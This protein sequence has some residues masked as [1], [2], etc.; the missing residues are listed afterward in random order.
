M[1]NQDTS[2]DT[3]ISKSPLLLKRFELVRTLGEGAVG[4][5]YLV[6]DKEKDNELVAL[7]VLTNE[8]DYDNH[9]VDRFQQEIKLLREIN[10]P[11]I[12]KAYD[13]IENGKSLA[14]TMEYVDG[15]DMGELFRSTHYSSEQIDSIFQQLLSALSEMHVRGIWHRDIKLENIMLAKD[16][17]IK[18]MDLGLVKNVFKKSLTRTGVLLGTAQY[19]PPEYVKNSAYDAR[20]DIYA[21]GIVL[22]EMLTHKRRM[23]DMNGNEVIEKLLKTNFQIPEISLSGL[24]RRY[25]N[26]IRRATAANPNDRYQSAAQMGDDFKNMYES[27]LEPE[28]SKIRESVRLKDMAK[29]GQ[30]RKKTAKFFMPAMAAAA[31]L[32]LVV[33][34]AQFVSFPF[35][36][37]KANADLS[38][39]ITPGTYNGKINLFTNSGFFKQLK[40]T[41][42]EKGI[43]IFSDLQECPKGFF[44]RESSAFICEKGTL[45]LSLT[46]VSGEAIYGELTDTVNSRTH[47]F[48]AEKS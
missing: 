14:Y 44:D 22:Y 10:H 31:F 5:V 20:S 1:Q 6:R 27:A 3:L 48:S 16:G 33:G 23:S 11:N 29:F 9:T 4:A 28:E 35:A 12:V 38:V 18:L 42:D 25:V 37:A 13:V 41:K 39:L 30:P 8:I 26:I 15:K 17:R 46:S 32:I 2:T 21:V 34:A 19:M 24:P 43:S 47:S 36:S 40:I 45:N 7:K